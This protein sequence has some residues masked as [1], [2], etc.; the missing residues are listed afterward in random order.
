MTYQRELWCIVSGSE[1][2]FMCNITP[3]GLEVVGYRDGP[4]KWYRGEDGEYI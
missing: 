1:V 2:R 4:W 3:S